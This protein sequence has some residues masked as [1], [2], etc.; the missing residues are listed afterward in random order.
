MKADHVASELASIVLTEEAIIRRVGELARQIEQD[1]DRKDLVLVGILGGAA[2]ATVD[3][4]RAME[5]HV[6]V[7]WMAVRS[8]GMGVRSSGSVRLLKDIDIDLSGRNVVIVDGII[9]T[10]L[11]AQW[12]IANITHRGAASVQMCALFRKPSAPADAKYIGFDVPDGMIVGYGLD[13]AGR[14]RNLRCC[15]VLAPHAI[16]AE[17]AVRAQGTP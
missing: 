9:D 11:T 2:T 7:T 5:R 13:Y 6:E 12:V 4:A 3:L 10:G 14:F 1:Y 15:A 16:R 8:Y 17:S